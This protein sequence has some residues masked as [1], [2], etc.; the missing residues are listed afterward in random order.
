V[1]AVPGGGARVFLTGAT[2]FIGGRLAAA[3]HGR[4]YRL[5]CLVR[6]P[7]RARALAGMGAELIEGDVTSAAALARGL[8]GAG[9]AFH[10]AA[11][12]EIGIVD[13]RALQQVN[14]EGTRAFLD[15]VR[16]AAAPL[17]IHVSST[18]ALG[19]VPAGEGDEHSA[20]DGPYPSVYHRTKTEAHRLALAAQRD[21]L[22]L[23]IVCPANVYGPGDEGPGGRF[24][25]DILR[26]RLPGL[27]TRPSVFSY[28]HVDDVVD[29]LIAAAERGTPGSTYVL[30]G[31]AETVN[32]FARRVADLAGTWVSPLR[33]P[34]ALVRATGALM[35]AVS[36]LAGWGMPISRELAETGGSGDRWVHSHARATADLGYAPRTLA[37]GL[38]ETVLH[39]RQQLRR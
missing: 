15:A 31:E 18:A 23:T 25:L 35:D 20:Y 1:S 32:G 22:P 4:G 26:H 2:G 27:S 38:P 16:N 17:A 28:V 29:G 34:P 9:L 39:A 12:Y 37:E 36:R 13:A 11:R 7:E 3:L 24:V 10:L 14:V 5:R 19:P 21:G 8:E 33:F 6:S 30:S